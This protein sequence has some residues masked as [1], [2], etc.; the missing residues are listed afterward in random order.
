MKA[1]LILHGS[2]P[3]TI[4][5]NEQ[6]DR[7]RIVQRSKK[8]SNA[9]EEIILKPEREGTYKYTFSHISDS[10]YETV[11]L[12]GND[13]SITQIVHPLASA[14]FVRNSANNRGARGLSSCSGKQVDVQ[15][16]LRVWSL[17]NSACSS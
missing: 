3:Y 8:T 1:Q 13:L 12:T 2:P 7:E 15:V 4:H 9:R 16:E 5:Y 14:E 6:R 17:L 10:N 11:P